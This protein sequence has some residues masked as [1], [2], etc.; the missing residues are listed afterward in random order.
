MSIKHNVYKLKQQHTRWNSA[1]LV[2]LKLLDQTTEDF[3]S[4]KANNQTNGTIYLFFI[5]F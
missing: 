3:G 4:H 5:L 2:F 1:Q